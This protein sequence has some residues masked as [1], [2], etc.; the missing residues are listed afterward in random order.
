MIT[1]RCR[2]LALLLVT[3]GLSVGAAQPPDLTGSWQWKSRDIGRPMQI[4]QNA[5]ELVIEAVGLPQGAVDERFWLDG[6]VRVETYPGPGFV[7]RYR[8]SGRWDGRTWVGTIEA[9]AGWDEGTVAR[10]P[11]TVVTRW[12]TLDESGRRLTVRSHGAGSPS[13]ESPGDYVYQFDRMP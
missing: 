2:V 3:A 12:F 7:R 6:R 5:D 11:H 1:A 4:R 10:R 13:G 8:T 9:F